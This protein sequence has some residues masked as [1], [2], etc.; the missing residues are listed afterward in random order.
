MATDA[1]VPCVAK[2]SAAI[3]STMYGKRLHI[4]H[5]EKFSTTRRNLCVIYI[6]IY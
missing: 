3:V 6:H 2:Q 4:S 1:P 5:G